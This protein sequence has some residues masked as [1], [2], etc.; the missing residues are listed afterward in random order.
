MIPVSISGLSMTKA[1]F[2]VLLQS[3]VDA[4]TLP[5]FIGL[6][7]TQAI[8]I[9][10]SDIRPPRPMTHDLMKSILAKLEAR[11]DSVVVCR[12]E[13]ATFY[14]KLL[15][16]V[17]GKPLEIDSRP[18]DAI[19]LALRCLVPIYVVD[20][21]MDEA[22]VVLGEGADQAAEEEQGADSELS[23]MALLETELANAI[24]DERYEDAAKL[25]DEI[26]CQENAN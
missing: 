3:E 6:P 12:L 1:G 19:A 22:G 15:L 14:A 4:R 8:H 10:L 21:V 7:E 26:K 25:R 11:L 18:S 20:E 23:A 16:T 5:V 24:A 13:E 9:Q 2:V 17:A